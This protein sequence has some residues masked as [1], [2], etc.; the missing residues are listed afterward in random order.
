MS[1]ESKLLIE[2]A[3]ALSPAERASVAD[4]LLS[5]LDQSDDEIDQV[6]AS[7]VEARIRA[8]KDG[9]LKTVP[10]EALLS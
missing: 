6:W 4:K 3:L 7:E 10:V 1:D 8:Y 5:S 9:K 2:K